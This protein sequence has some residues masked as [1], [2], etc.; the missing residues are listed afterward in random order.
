[1]T[2]NGY[3]DAPVGDRFV[4]PHEEQMKMR[5][6]LSILNDNDGS[7]DVVYIQKQNSSFTDEFSELIPDAGMMIFIR[8]IFYFFFKRWGNFNYS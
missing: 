5:D 4:L 3:A 7:K 2:P 6:F 1:M 8:A